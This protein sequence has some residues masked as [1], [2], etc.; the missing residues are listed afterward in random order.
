MNIR[1]VK[2]SIG[3]F[4]IVALLL[5]H[6]PLHGQESV[7]DSLMFVPSAGDTVA[8]LSDSLTTAGD[9][10]RAG[11]DD[12]SIQGPIKYWA[13]DIRLSDGGDR[14]Q[15]AGNAKLHYQNLTLTAA[16][17]HI[18]RKTHKL[19]A[20]GVVDSVDADSN[21]YYTG[22][23]VFEEE[24]ERPL[25][26]DS[27]EYD[28]ETRRGKISGG[29]TEMEPG[30][31]KGSKINKIGDKTMLVRTGYFTSCEYID[32]PHYYFKSKRMRVIIKDKVIAEPI[33]FYIADVPLMWLPFGVFPNKGGR[34]SG[35]VV[36]TY[37]ENRFGGRFL[38]GMG[39]YWAPNDYFDAAFLVDFYDKIGFT[40]RTDVRYTV[41]YQLNGSLSA[42]YFPRDPYSGRRTER[43]RVRFSHNQTIDP[44]MQLSGSGSFSSDRNFASQLSP[45]VEDRLNQ[46]I[47][48]NLSLRKR[49]PGT[50][51]SFSISLSRNENLQTGNTQYT[52]PRAN[53]NR[54]QSSLYETLTGEKLGG[55]RNWFQNIYFSYNSNLVHR[56]SKTLQPD[57]TFKRS[58]SSGIQHNLSFNAPQKIF[59][60]F[61]IRPTLRYEE[62]WVNEVA[63][64]RYDAENDQVVVEKDKQFA[65]LRTFNTGLALNTTLY[66]LFE[67]NI[68]ALKLIRHKMDPSI[69]ISYRPDFSSPFY[70]NMDEVTDSTGRVVGEVDRFQFSPFGRTP[71]GQSRS[72]NIRIGNLFQGKL[73]DAEGRETKIDLLSADVSTSKNF[74]ADSLQ[75]S[76]ITS[77]LR[78]R[79]MGK[80]ISV[81]MRHNPYQLSKD[82][83]QIIDRF[84]TL[85][86]LTYLSTGFN[87]SISNKTFQREEDEDSPAEADTL[88][89]Q[90]PNEGILNNA[91]IENVDRDYKEQ[92]KKIDV[93]WS[94]SFNFSYSYRNNPGQEARTDFGL[95]MRANLR[96]T[97][98]WKVSWNASFDM[99]ERKLTSQYFSIYRDLHCWEMSFNW[100]PQRGY[101]S[102]QINVKAS[103]LR[104][105]K[106][107]KQA[108]GSSFIPNY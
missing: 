63:K 34:H 40:Y 21:V 77:S 85:P 102:F 4:M 2:H 68:G 100:Q 45:N 86:R 6:W 42:E 39:Y 64:G 59:K 17:I 14:I 105:I 35:I 90:P 13:D 66:G 48:S 81:R 8:A 106:V 31:Y 44:T 18:N 98:N 99:T 89:R 43:W 101:Y 50:K 108:S 1:N 97:K 25:Y 65:A 87:F 46:N 94:T 78:T 32:H 56:G 19:Y 84:A 9:T 79:I 92:T 91:R 70:G 24:G 74:L 7:S 58:E 26:G 11:Q 30:Y 75:W 16:R 12:S 41:R 5:G 93:P 27:I 38:R 67:P 60:Y 82:G 36:P 55:K 76:P 107:E 62:N 52:L 20:R 37:G 47:N 49:W 33:F 10:A 96:P 15:L 29:K 73:I 23:P 71:S 22:T 28:F 95:R 69:Q 72:M 88:G 61:N 103:A 54:S 51:N 3:Q 80:S 53:F 83:S 57:S 104:D